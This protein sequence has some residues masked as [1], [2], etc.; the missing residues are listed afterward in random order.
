MQWEIRN[1]YR[2]LMELF[3]FVLKRKNKEKEE[4]AMKNIKLIGSI[5]L[6]RQ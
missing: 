4:K 2:A 5:G 3:F 6:H 1:A